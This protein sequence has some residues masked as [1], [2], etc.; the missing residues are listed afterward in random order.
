MEQTRHKRTQL[1][2]IA[3]HSHILLIQVGVGSRVQAQSLH[4]LPHDHPMRQSPHHLLHADLHN[5]QEAA[6]AEKNVGGGTQLGSAGTVLLAS[7]TIVTIIAEAASSLHVT[8]VAAHTVAAAQLAVDL[9][10]RNGAC[11][12][13]L[14]LNVVRAHGVFHDGRLIGERVGVVGTK[15]VQTKASV[16]AV[17]HVV[18]AARVLHHDARSGVVD[19]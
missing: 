2:H 6:H 10:A 1:C 9:T 13:G 3:D 12:L 8:I 16:L 4:L 19:I 17:A 18:A 14:H 7:S 11:E 5:E 15:Q